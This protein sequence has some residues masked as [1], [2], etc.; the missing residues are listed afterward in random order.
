[1]KSH[2]TRLNNIPKHKSHS[3]YP[4]LDSEQEAKEYI[5]AQ[6]PVVS[7]NVMVGLLAVYKNTLVRNS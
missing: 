2:Q 3:L 6:V 5:L 7:R 1:M 4:T